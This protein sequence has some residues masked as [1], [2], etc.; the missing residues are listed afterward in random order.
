MSPFSD[1]F[2]A[3]NIKILLQDVKQPAAALSMQVAKEAGNKSSR[4][5]PYGLSQLFDLQWSGIAGF[6]LTLDK[7]LP[8]H[9]AAISG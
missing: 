5:K 1:I 3:K 9:Y 7:L 6:C 8:Y 4:T 2:I